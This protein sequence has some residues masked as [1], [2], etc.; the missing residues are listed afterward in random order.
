MFSLD[1]LPGRT[2][3]QDHTEW[4]Y[5][6]GTS[7]LGMSMLPAFRAALTEGFQYYGTNFG[8]SRNGNLQLQVYE[9]TE[10]QLAKW[11]GMEAALTLSS[12]TL[13]GQMVVRYLQNEPHR[14]WLFAP[15]VHP[16][17]WNPAIHFKNDISFEEW[18]NR[19]ISSTYHRSPHP[20]SIFFSSVDPLYGDAVPLD[21]ITRLPASNTYQIII[22]DSHGLGLLG[23]EGQGICS[24]L[25]DTPHIEFII[26]ASMG[27]AL[28]LPGGIILGQQSLIE[29]LKTSAFCSGASPMI[30]A[31][32]YAWQC[33]KH[34]IHNQRHTLSKNITFL[35]KNWPEKLPLNHQ[36]GYPVFCPLTSGLAPQLAQRKILISAFPYPTPTSPMLQRIVLNSQHSLD[37]LQILVAVMQEFDCT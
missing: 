5:F 32:L 26:V 7:Y 29:K 2:F 15:N 25:P 9:E 27:K 30:P 17:L 37:D 11:I 35:E 8:G 18:T 19:V 23:P 13:A 16:A 28:D 3:R 14:E 1:H 10:S 6:S 31:Y 4:L 36:K 34:L 12:G 24:M 20:Y 22:D 21:W 33:T